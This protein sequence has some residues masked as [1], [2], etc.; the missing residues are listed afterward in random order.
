MG[1][2]KVIPISYVRALIR[3][4]EVITQSLVILV[5]L[6]LI[7]EVSYAYNQVFISGHK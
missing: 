3:F 4:C 5:L 6:A 1:V 2:E 7:R